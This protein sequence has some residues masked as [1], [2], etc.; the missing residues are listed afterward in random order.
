MKIKNY[1]IDI[2]YFE[3]GHILIGNIKKDNYNKSSMILY[4][5]KFFNYILHRVVFDTKKEAEKYL[6]LLKNEIKN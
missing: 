5:D 6:S 2:K 4:K 1:T 3:G